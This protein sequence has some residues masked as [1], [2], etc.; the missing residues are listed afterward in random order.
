MH[1]PRPGARTGSS[2]LPSA[3][4]AGR[5][6]MRGPGMS[7]TVSDGR[8][9]NDCDDRTGRGFALR[10]LPGGR[11]PLGVPARPRPI[12]TGLGAALRPNCRRRRTLDGSASRCYP[13]RSQ[14]PCSTPRSSRSIDTWP[15][16]RSAGGAAT[17]RP[18][19]T[20]HIFGLSPASSFSK[21]SD[22][23]RMVA[24]RANSKR[25]FTSDA[26]TTHQERRGELRPQG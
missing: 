11:R 9:G 14:P 26:T 23:G 18:N 16:G 24:P 7:G 2:D 20:W 15:V 3:R 1:L 22:R 25:A 8:Q 19:A 17:T 4:R 5:W 10:T 13:G 6:P 21:A 12:S